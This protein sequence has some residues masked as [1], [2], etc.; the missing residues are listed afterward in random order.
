[1]RVLGWVPHTQ[2]H[3]VL[4]NLS[5]GTEDQ[6]K[7]ANW[8]TSVP[9]GHCWLQ[10][11]GTS[12]CSSHLAGS[13]KTHRVWPSCQPQPCLGFLQSCIIFFPEQRR[14][15]AICLTAQPPAC[16]TCLGTSPVDTDKTSTVNSCDVC[17]KHTLTMLNSLSVTFDIAML[18][19]K[20]DIWAQ[21][22]WSVPHRPTVRQSSQAQIV[23]RPLPW[24]QYLSLFQCMHHWQL[25]SGIHGKAFGKSQADMF[26]LLA[27]KMSKYACWMP[28]FR[29]NPEKLLFKKSDRISNFQNN[30][31]GLY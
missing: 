15:L 16:A 5:K 20:L 31:P 21:E 18:Y 6:T 17:P 19:P 1:M 11:Y 24:R 12:S 10:G 3:P 8:L 14:A 25:L 27:V 4:R 30:L 9:F 28:S 23:L 22:S 29:L 2:K 26:I 13:V 7:K